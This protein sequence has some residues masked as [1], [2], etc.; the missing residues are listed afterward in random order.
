MAK[1]ITAAHRKRF[2][3]LREAGCI[4]CRPRGYREPAIHHLVEGNRLG[5]DFT[6]PLCPWCHQ[7]VPP[8]G[9]TYKQAIEELGPYFHGMRIAFEAQ[10]GTERDLLAKTNELLGATE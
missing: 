10:Y 5:H 9:L 2:A 3:A 4:T 7:G 8:D 6:I 1:S